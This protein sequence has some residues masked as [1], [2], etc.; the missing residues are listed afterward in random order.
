MHPPRE[1]RKF[2]R[3]TVIG[4]T[5]YSHNKDGNHLYNCACSCGGSKTV[6][7]ANLRKGDTKSCGCLAREHETSQRAL[8]AENR[9]RK[10]AV[11]AARLCTLVDGVPPSRH[12]LWTT[13]KAMVKRCLYPKHDSYGQY[14]AKG[15]M[16]CE[17]WLGDRAL[18]GV[19]G[20]RQFFQDMGNKPTPTHQLDRLNGEAGY[21]PENCRWVTPFEQYRNIPSNPPMHVATIRGKTARL[22][23][24]AAKF[25]V[26]VSAIHKLIKSGL[27]PEHA[28]FTAYLNKK[29]W[30]VGAHKEYAGNREKAI[31]YVLKYCGR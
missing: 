19:K 6:R 21:S 30:L 3:L 27:S 4:V 14:G 22:S 18:G 28:V 10:A 24:W 2:G 7:W 11:R 8:G 5:S 9:S 31:A 25:G 20:F 12:P 23:Q 1:G 17:Q 29:S 26:S 15:V 13:Y 16:V